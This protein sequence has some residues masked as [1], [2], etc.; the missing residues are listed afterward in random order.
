MY[1]FKRLLP[2]ILA[3]VIAVGGVV[4][5]RY[6][7]TRRVQGIQ[8]RALVTAQVWIAT[9][10]YRDNPERFL[11]YRDSVL[12]ASG[13]TTMEMNRYLCGYDNRTEDGAA[14]VTL[15]SHYVDSLLGIGDSNRAEQK[16]VSLD[17][18]S[19]RR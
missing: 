18:G 11:E 16:E 17:S 8:K 10:R 2:L 14:F 1:A 7:V 5:H 9:A 13:L 4:V 6:T 12:E 15:V 19:I 3:L